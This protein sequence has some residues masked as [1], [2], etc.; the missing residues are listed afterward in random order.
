MLGFAIFIIALLIIGVI[1][2][3]IYIFSNNPGTKEELLKEITP[4][5]PELIN[6][7]DQ[8][9]LD[10]PK[11]CEEELD[12]IGYN[13]SL[14]I[15]GAFDYIRK[16]PLQHLWDED[17]KQLE[18]VKL[19]VQSTGILF[20]FAALNS[21]EKETFFKLDKPKLR[22]SLVELEESIKALN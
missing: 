9:N 11:T 5:I 15:A 20:S 13:L 14:D 12:Q 17:A 6:A 21:C 4:I 10:D 3:Q 8:A 7:L 18:D 22:Q 1:A 2:I 16:I 19:E